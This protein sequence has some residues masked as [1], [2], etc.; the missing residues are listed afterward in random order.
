MSPVSRRDN[1]IGFYS[2]SPVSGAPEVVRRGRIRSSSNGR[3]AASVVAIEG[4][5]QR[6][7][8]IDYGV[9]CRHSTESKSEQID[10]RNERTNELA[11]IEPN[12]PP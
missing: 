1:R 3:I 9:Q 8:A 11:N 12:D 5:V 10:Y 6:R 2:L 7:G 4:C